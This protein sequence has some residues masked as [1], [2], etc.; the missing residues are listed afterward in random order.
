M[1]LRES[2]PLTT[3][4]N[5]EDRTNVG[6]TTGMESLMEIEVSRISH[7]VDTRVCFQGLLRELH[8]AMICLGGP[9]PIVLTAECLGHGFAP[10]EFRVTIFRPSSQNRPPFEHSDEPIH[11]KIFHG[12]PSRLI[13]DF[14]DIIVDQPAFPTCIDLWL[15]KTGPPNMF[16]LMV[17]MVHNPGRDHVF[18]DADTDTTLHPADVNAPTRL[19]S[20]SDTIHS[21]S[22]HAS[23]YH[24]FRVDAAAGAVFGHCRCNMVG[25]DQMP[26]RDRLE[27]RFPDK[28]C[29]P[30]STEGRF[31]YHLG[32]QVLA[33]VELG[34]VR[35][36]VSQDELDDLFSTLISGRCR[37][38]SSSQT[39]LS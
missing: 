5:K 36:V 6:L 3:Q 11:T 30:Y 24:A 16:E 26:D 21:V 9:E 1:T 32:N 18:F 29:D 34:Q 10:R 17:S 38:S 8:H 4:F 7:V 23:T 39:C 12:I 25:M 37:G 15:R 2:S 27:W 13:L 35:G 28:R 19:G 22:C 33:I 20:S 14:Q 31:E